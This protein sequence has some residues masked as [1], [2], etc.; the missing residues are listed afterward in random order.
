MLLRVTRDFNKDHLNKIVMD[1]EISTSTTVCKIGD[2]L[3][4]ELHHIKDGKL[5]F[6][7]YIEL[8]NTFA[9]PYG[10]LISNE[11]LLAILPN[12]ESVNI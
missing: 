2:I 12:V 9:H 5:F 6:L 1:L 3:R 4:L 10:T 7:Y 11:E 8:S